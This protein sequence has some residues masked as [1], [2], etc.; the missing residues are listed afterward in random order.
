MNKK[1]FFLFL[2][3]IS[4]TNNDA[5]EGDN[6][7]NNKNYINAIEYYNQSIKLN[8]NNVKSIYRR[9]RSY[10]EI[11]KY[12]KAYDDYMK[13]ITIDKKYTSA[14]LSIAIYHHRNSDFLLSESYSKKAIKINSDLYLAH[15]WLGRSYQNQGNFNEAMKSFNNSISLNKNFPENYFYKGI[16]FLSLND[17]N[18]ACKNFLI[19]KSLNFVESSDLLKKYCR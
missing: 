16:I 6:L 4:C 3:I 9:G 17:S 12:K 19:S 7:Y 15:Y 5:Q 10:E 11:G 18:K 13:V 1:Y 8:P 2:I 14:Y